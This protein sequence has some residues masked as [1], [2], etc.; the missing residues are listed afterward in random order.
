MVANERVSI[1]VPLYN[2]GFYVRRALE[3]ILRQTYPCFE[4]VVVD[5]GSTDEG[6]AAVQ[7][8][9]AGD[10]RISLVAQ[11][12]AG[13][14]AA[15]NRAVHEAKGSL[16]AFLDADDEWEPHFLDLAFATFEA[17]PTASAVALAYRIIYPSGSEHALDFK[18]GIHAGA[19]GIIENYFQ[20]L[21]D[22]DPPVWTSSV[23]VRRSVFE[24]LGGFPPLL[25][26]EDTAFWSSVALSYSIAFANVVSAT[27]HM[28]ADVAYRATMRLLLVN[29]NDAKHVLSPLD[30]AL[31]GSLPVTVA[32]AV[33]RYRQRRLSGDDPSK[34]DVRA[35]R[36]CPKHF[37]PVWAVQRQ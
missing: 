7:N 15:R 32:G 30:E 17:Y 1:V 31:A 4:V 19:T 22:G 8:L 24:R 16:I 28:D 21:L 33:R 27:F 35:S 29:E 12:N 10:D 26:G 37:C 20:S 13:P 25:R 9:A 36:P 18:C 11:A 6:P 2:K 5:D 14:G 34:L 3:S 23:V